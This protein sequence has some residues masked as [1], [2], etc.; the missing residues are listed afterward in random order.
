MP[1][2]VAG[3]VG[4]GIVLQQRGLVGQVD[5][6]RVPPVVPETQ[7]DEVVPVDVVDVEPRGLEH[8]GAAVDHVFAVPGAIVGVV[9][10]GYV[11]LPLAVKF[12]ETSLKTYGLD[13][14]KK[15]INELK[16]KYDAMGEVSKEE[17]KKTN[18]EY[19]TNPS[20]ISKCNFI[21]V[22]V[23]TSA[24][25]G[26]I[27]VTTGGDQPLVDS[28]DDDVG[29]RIADFEVNDIER[30]GLCSV[31]PSNGDVSEHFSVGHVLMRNN[32]NDVLVITMRTILETSAKN[33]NITVDIV[34][35]FC[36]R[37]R[38]NPNVYQKT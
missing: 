4:D 16:K 9:G 12:G 27:R 24:V 14:N 22:A 30:P 18:V 1:V 29:A 15:K 8:V 6:R 28:T 34:Y 33:H 23:P 3:V 11:G 37:C 36:G 38:I 17:L 20:I 21:I 25:S 32:I 13:L 10:L 31:L 26:A 35:Y 7:V 2:L 5:A 19:T